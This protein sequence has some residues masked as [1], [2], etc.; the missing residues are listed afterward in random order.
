[1]WGAAFKPDSDD[2]RDSPA[3]DVAGALHL[4]GAHVTVYDPQADRQRPARFPTLSYADS[5]HRRRPRR[6]PGAAPDRVAGVPRPSTSTTLGG[7][8]AHR[9]VLD[10]RNALDLAAWRSAGWEARGIGRR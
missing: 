4:R 6:R 8:V 3:L 5:A 7:V 1:M 9:R 2:I 10:G